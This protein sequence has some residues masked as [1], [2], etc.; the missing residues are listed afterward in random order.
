[1]VVLGATSILTALPAGTP[2]LNI[3]NVMQNGGIS[4]APESDGV[5]IIHYATGTMIDA[6]FYEAST[7][8]PT[9]TVATGVG[10]VTMDFVEGTR[11]QF[12]DPGAGSLERKK[13]GT[14]AAPQDTND[15]NAD[16]Q[17]ITTPTPGTL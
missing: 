1:V 14:P 8:S 12:E 17:L 9:F 2:R 15:N 16:F 5:G 4:T 11:T 7:Q 10:D 6:L 13:T 3:G